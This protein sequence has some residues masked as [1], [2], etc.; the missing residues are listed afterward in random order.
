MPQK[1]GNTSG[2][3]C[4]PCDV[5]GHPPYRSGFRLLLRPQAEKLARPRALVSVRCQAITVAEAFVYAFVAYKTRTAFIAAEYHQANAFVD[6]LGLIYAEHIIACDQ[7]CFEFE[8]VKR[9]VEDAQRVNVS[10]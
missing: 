9:R 6:V 5:G 3:E 8:F 10:V 7:V 1:G 2:R 4:A